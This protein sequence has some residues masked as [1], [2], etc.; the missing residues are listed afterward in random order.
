[1]F[2]REG[3]WCEP[4]QKCIEP[5][6]ELHVSYVVAVP[7]PAVMGYECREFSLKLGGTTDTPCSP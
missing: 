3:G 1:M 5:T 2:Q 4:L 7:V 6:L